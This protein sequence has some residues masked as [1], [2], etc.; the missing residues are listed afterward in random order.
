MKNNERTSESHQV[1][2]YVT[3]KEIYFKNLFCST[4]CLLTVT[5]F[6]KIIIITIYDNTKTQRLCMRT[7]KFNHLELYW[8]LSVS[9][10]LIVI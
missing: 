6:K 2:I 9:Y 4:V 7:I 10:Q 1:C 8:K 5:E 3:G